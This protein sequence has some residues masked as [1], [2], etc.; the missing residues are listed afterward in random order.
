MVS[1]VKLYSHLDALEAEL[2]E[3]LILLLEQAAEDGEGLIFCVEDFNTFPELQ[4]K[5]NN[6]TEALISLGRQILSL[7]SKLG[8]SSLGSIAE[9][10]CWYCREWV[11]LGKP[12]V[13]HT[14][15]LARQFLEE[16]E[17]Q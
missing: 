11:D 15:S 12:Y 10:L 9:R 1:K 4:S 16:I 17:K 6:E 8:E 3:K 14:K 13:K 2:K 5:I 7:Q